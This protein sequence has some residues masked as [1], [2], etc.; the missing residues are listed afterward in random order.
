[1]TTLSSLRANSSTSSIESVS[2]LLYTY[3]HLTYFLFPSITSGLIEGGRE[4]V[5]E[6]VG[7]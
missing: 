3:K 6:E 4:G 5:I 7:E 2:I 1:M